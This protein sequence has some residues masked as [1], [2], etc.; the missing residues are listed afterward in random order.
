[1]RKKF[2]SPSLAAALAGALLLAGCGGAG[3]LSEPAESDIDNGDQTQN[4]SDGSAE[5]ALAA[6]WAPSDTDWYLYGAQS[7][8]IIQEN[9]GLDITVQESAGS[10]ENAIRMD[11]C[12]VD[13]GMLDVSGA[14]AALGE[15]QLTTL[16]PLSVVL[17]QL[18]VGKDTGITDVGDLE[19]KE[20][21][22]GPIGGGSTQTT[23]DVLEG[24]GIQPNY[25]EATLS[26]AVS[27]YMGRQIAGFSYRGAGVQATG[28][29]LEGASSRPIDL[30]DFNDEQM[31]QIREAQPDLIPVTIPGG[32]YSDVPEDTQTFGYWG[33]I[34]GASDCVDEETAYT[35]TKTFWENIEEVNEQL[36]QTEG[37]TPEVALEE[38]ILPLHAGAARYYEEIGLEV[39]DDMVAS[40]SQ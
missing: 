26:D 6:S 37:L 23:M 19:G 24:L 5:G 30:I 14:E 20:W 39:P 15:H 4:D 28:A 35:I 38:L 32:T 21:N 17:W 3:D 36:P 22:P 29:V 34:V 16:Y 40:D 18:I 13:V 33:V 12:L 2:S 8:A 11:E 7:M 10:E 9:S 27:A 31:K 1:M 25:Y